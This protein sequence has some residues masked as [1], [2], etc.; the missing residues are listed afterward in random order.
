MSEEMNEEL[1]FEEDEGYDVDMSDFIDEESAE[2]PTEEE[3]PTEEPAEG[4]NPEE[5]EQKEE[6]EETPP[7]DTTPTEEV[8]ELKYDKQVEKVNR[9][10]VVELAQKGMNYDRIVEQR[11]R[12]R[13]ENEEYR[14][15]Q[16]ENTAT[17]ELLN[18]A[19]SSSGMTVPQ[20]LKTVRENVLR[21]KGLSN[22]AI[23]ERIARE[24][25]ERKL[26]E[27]QRADERRDQETN[28]KN[29]Q[30]EKQKREVEAFVSAYPN[31]DP[32][33]ISQ[34]VWDAVNRGES[35]LSAYTR[36][37][38]KSLQSKVKELTSTIEA[39]QQNTKNKEKSVGSVK[40]DGKETGKDP[41]LEYFMADD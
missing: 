30:T 11:D 37:E 34:E 3:T 24:D 32:K 13:Q 6:N 36:Q 35:L 7:E 19:V 14:K 18:A 38:N 20:F 23:A 33:S 15:F 29:A 9:E 17:L 26:A 39:M 25:A 8:F 40:S 28:E 41:F 31:V 2:E 27:K 16:D 4:E 1:G 22:D 12:L 10:K 5:Q 21:S